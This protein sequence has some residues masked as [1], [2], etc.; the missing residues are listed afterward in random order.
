MQ[1]LD[2]ARH[3]ES[4]LAAQIAPMRTS[5]STNPSGTPNH[6]RTTGISAFLSRAVVHPVRAQRGTS[7]RRHDPYPVRAMA[8]QRFG[9]LCAWKLLQSFGSCRAGGV[10]P[11][12]GASRLRA[13]GGE[14]AQRVGRRHRSQS[15]PAVGIRKG[16]CSPWP[17]T[18]CA[19]KARHALD[20]SRRSEPRRHQAA[21]R[22]ELGE[23]VRDGFVTLRR[24]VDL[25]ARELRRP[26][27][28]VSDRALQRREAQLLPER[29]AGATLAMRRRARSAPGRVDVCAW[30][31]RA[32]VSAR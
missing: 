5:T 20:V 22:E 25:V 31:S 3:P 7:S 28:F 17:R 21:L 8:H 29:D 1:G 19:T 12:A 32:V 4:S 9:G 24:Q 26:L 2:R 13:R 16:G 15:N 30:S 23:R 11:P 10:A 14:C 18:R 27:S 6:Q